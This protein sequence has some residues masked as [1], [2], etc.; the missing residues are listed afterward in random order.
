MMQFNIAVNMTPKT[1]CYRVRVVPKLYS[2]SLQVPLN[3]IL[4][5]DT[6]VPIIE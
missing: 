4:I 5:G 6:M 2:S 3:S 1:D